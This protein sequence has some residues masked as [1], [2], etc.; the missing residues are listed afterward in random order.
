MPLSL[1]DGGANAFSQIVF[2]PADS[3]SNPG[4]QEFTLDY[5]QKLGQGDEAIARHFAHYFGDFLLRK[6]RRKLSVP[7][8]I[9][10]VRQETFMRVL[11]VV[12]GQGALNDP[13][14]FGPSSTASAITCS[15]NII[16]RV[17]GSH[18]F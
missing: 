14:R 9:D 17:T 15:P 6:L 16:A 13:A 12:H 8:A 3:F 1:G 4:R 18:T 10:D 2:A 11:R 5:V 7:E